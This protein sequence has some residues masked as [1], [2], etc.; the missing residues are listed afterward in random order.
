MGRRATDATEP[1]MSDRQ[2]NSQSK[3][4]GDAV[5]SST[6][7]PPGNNHRKDGGNI[8][9]RTR[10]FRSSSILMQSRS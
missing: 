7:D 5:F 1:L 2:V 3:N 10:R 6:G 4:K 9:R 8:L